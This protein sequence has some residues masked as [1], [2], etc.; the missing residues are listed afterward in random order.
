VTGPLSFRDRPRPRGSGRRVRPEV[1]TGI[2]IVVFLSLALLK[3]WGDGAP[4][5][6]DAGH[7]ASG[8]PVAPGAT[9]A[10]T[11]FT[12]RVTPAPPVVALTPLDLGLS[13]P[14]AS[15]RSIESWGSLDWQRLPSGGASPFLTSVLGWNG[16][17]IALAW[18]PNAAESSVWTSGDGSHWDLLPF[19]TATTFWPRSTIVGLAE[20]PDGLVAVTALDTGCVDAAP[21]ALGGP[22]IVSWTSTDGV[23][24][25]PGGLPDLGPDE[26]LRGVVV[27][28]SPDG[29]VAVS[30]G[31]HVASATTPDGRR[32]TA[33]DA[34]GMGP[35]TVVSDAVGTS[36]GFLV[37]GSDGVGPDTRPTVWR[38]QDGV[39]WTPSTLAGLPGTDGG[40]AGSIAT[41]LVV[42]RDG[43]IAHVR[44]V[45]NVADTWWQTSDAR[46][47][48]PMPTAPR[49]GP[50]LFAI[51][52]HLVGDLLAGDGSRIVAFRGGGFPVAWISI[53]GRS[54]RQIAV[55]GDLPSDAAQRAILVPG[56]MLVT[57]GQTAWLGIA[58]A[59]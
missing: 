14:D 58:G 18:M 22:P 46:A 42:G 11:T 4:P 33:A 9:P 53:D 29:L 57:D 2:A 7:S 25:T 34:V 44:G 8:R 52:G 39:S 43:V 12:T 28:S 59:G 32:W 5:D 16:G 20:L 36:L 26:A 51:D 30:A 41:S 17:F 54:W 56:G 55:R 1:A 27:A 3:P 40:R 13:L 35:T 50:W 15:A 37:A 45:T 49:K 48:Q 38:S 24:W 21:C 10:P 23:S 6:V 31:R 19:A 47:W